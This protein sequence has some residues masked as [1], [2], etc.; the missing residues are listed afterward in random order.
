MQVGYGITGGSG[1]NLMH[2]GGADGIP[3]VQADFSKGQYKTHMVAA[4]TRVR[5]VDLQ[6]GNMTGRNMDSLLRDGLRLTYDKHM[7]ENT[8]VGF[9]RFGTTGLLNNPGCHRNKRGIQWRND[10]QYKVQ[11]Q[12]AG[13][14]F[15]GHQRGDPLSVECLRER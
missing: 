11:G 9:S 12:D 4:G 1:D 8:Y 15:K 6:R 10:I 2:S 3:M 7:D 5:W 13:S 14:D